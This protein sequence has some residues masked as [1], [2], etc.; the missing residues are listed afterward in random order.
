LAKR[1]ASEGSDDESE[2]VSPPPKKKSR[3]R[4][5]TTTT[6]SPLSDVDS[7]DSDVALL[8]V[9]K[10]SGTSSSEAIDLEESEDDKASKK[11]KKERR[12]VNRSQKRWSG[13]GSEPD[14]L[15]REVRSDEESSIGEANEDEEEGEES[16]YA[17]E[18]ED[19]NEANKVLNDVEMLTSEIIGEIGMWSSG[20][21]DVE[22]EGD[23]GGTE[24]AG[25]EEDEEDVMKANRNNG[26]SNPSPTTITSTPTKT[27]ENGALALTAVSNQQ[28]KMPSTWITK[29]HMSMLCPQLNLADYQL[30]GV[31]WLALL[32]RMKFKNS[33][34]ST[35]TQEEG[36]KGR[37]KEIVAQARKHV[38]N[39]ILA[40]EV[41]ERSERTCC[42]P[43]ARI[44]SKLP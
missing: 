41:S 3:R 16:D 14:D 23:K 30:L 25:L 42:V 40:D 9:S 24:G 20:A 37:K 12:A 15:F 38:V 44:R 8:A 21:N 17:D 39:G 19:L 29:E 1:L 33:T 43:L 7:D 36:G 10:T 27:N 22:E 5:T 13:A 6:S 2:G 31:N 26:S 18:E 11:L 32:S 35:A 34:R 4:N 28:Q